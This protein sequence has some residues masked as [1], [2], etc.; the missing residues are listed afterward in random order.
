MTVVVAACYRP[1][2]TTI[3]LGPKR[4]L[5]VEVLVDY[6]RLV[7]Q[8]DTGASTTSLTPAARYLLRPRQTLPGV[9]RG[10]G[11]ELKRVEYIGVR[12]IRLAGEVVRVAATVFDFET[13]GDGVLGMDVLGRY[14]LEVDLRAHR[15]ALHRKGST[16]F[17][18][19]DLVGV[20]YTPLVGGQIALP[21]TINGRPA[22]AVFDLGATGTFAN[23]HAG[24]VPDDEH[25][26][27][28]GAIGAD[29]N[30]LT[31]H[32][33]SDVEIGFGE[34][35]LRSRSVWINDLPI[36]HTF[37]LA[38]QPAMILGTDAL[39]GRRIVVDPF[40][41]RVYVSR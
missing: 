11:G 9:G 1:Q 8:L 17:L 39:A 36:F 25:A 15:Y 20:D 30:R 33:A 27:I 16:Q 13:A 12:S 35:V 23:R 3:T 5:L 38:A 18:S 34:L 37:D 32:A 14:V 24:L 26:T 41:R 29:R 28:T 22:T 31:F 6:K 2:P 4:E 40:A 10:A 21:V 19:D 7:L